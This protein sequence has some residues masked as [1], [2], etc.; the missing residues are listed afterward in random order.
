MPRFGFERSEP[1]SAEK[2]SRKR[3]CC[4][5]GHPL[6]THV[7]EG[8]GWRCHCLG[9]DTYQCECFLRKR[10]KSINGYDLDKRIRDKSTNLE[11]KSKG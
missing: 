1:F 2:R 3:T 5:C 10:Y 6:H 9:Q 7:D 4:C 11:Y 8:D